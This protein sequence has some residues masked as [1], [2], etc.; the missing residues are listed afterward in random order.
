MV[1]ETGKTKAN[2]WLENIDKITVG[3]L[4]STAKRE[5][6]SGKVLRRV[7]LDSLHAVKSLHPTGRL[8]LIFPFTVAAQY[9]IIGDRLYLV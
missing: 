7:W 1:T 9:A 5:R 2:N 4:F 3:L 6:L 8:W